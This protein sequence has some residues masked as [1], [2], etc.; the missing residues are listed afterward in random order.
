MRKQNQ[1]IAYFLSFCI[2][3]Y[4]HRQKKTG[5]ETATLF[6]QLGLLQYLAAHFDVLHSQSAQWIM[7]DIDDYINI[8]KERV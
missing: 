4:A 3:Q 5:A 2:E 7:E 1:D 8:R 6:D